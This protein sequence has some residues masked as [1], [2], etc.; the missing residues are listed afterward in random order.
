[1]LWILSTDVSRFSSIFRRHMRPDQ[2]IRSM[3]VWLMALGLSAFCARAQ[4]PTG[5]FTTKHNLS[6]AGSGEIRAT[7][8]EQV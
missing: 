7:T 8:E 5:I 1:M 6:V 2:C 3:M 4:S